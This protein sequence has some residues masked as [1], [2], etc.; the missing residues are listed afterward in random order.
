MPPVR[1]LPW[2]EVARKLRAAGFTEIGQQGSHV[3]FAKS[4]PHDRRVTVVPRHREVGVGLLR[5]IMR[6][7][8]LT[9]EDFERL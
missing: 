8:G 7:A 2:R 4:T 3:K 9:R 1:P 6:Q 5:A